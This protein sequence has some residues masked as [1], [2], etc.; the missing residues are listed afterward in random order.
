MESFATYFEDKQP[1]HIDY[2]NDNKDKLSDVVLGN[3]KKMEE[4]GVEPER[5][6]TYKNAKLKEHQKNIQ[7]VL[8][9]SIK[10]NEFEKVYEKLGMQ[11]FIP[12]S[13]NILE[14]ISKKSLIKLV[15]RSITV[16][17]NEIRDILPI[18]KPK[19]IIQ[20]LVNHPASKEAYKTG[21]KETPP[22]FFRDGIIYLDVTSI[23]NP[24]YFI[25]EYAHFIADKLPS[26]SKKLLTHTYRSMLDI[27]ARSVKKKRLG[28]R[29]LNNAESD[30]LREKIAKKLQF[31]SEYGFRDE[32]EFFAE[33]I[34][35]WKKFPN[36]SATY[37]FKQS[38]KQILNRL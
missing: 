4:L 33:V 9:T 24:D 38:V 7:N 23:D 31:P 35:H 21:E 8:R 22:A 1:T 28:G 10:S 27:Y 29:D 37:K 19:F 18:R 17:W 32:D 30:S 20:N 2:I 34:T 13:D 36:N 5:I 11:F 15:D 12:K 16:L 26:Q 6:E 3:I 14:Q 25:H